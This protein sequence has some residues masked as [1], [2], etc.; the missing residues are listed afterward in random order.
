MI[1][2]VD[3]LASRANEKRSGAAGFG[4]RSKTKDLTYTP[5]NSNEMQSFMEFLESEE[6]EGLRATEIGFHPKSKLRGVF[7][8]ESFEEG[9]FV[10]AIPFVSTLLI[11]ES[12]AKD[13]SEIEK[14]YQFHIKHRRGVE[15]SKWKPYLDCLPTR[16]SHFSA[17]ADF[18]EDDAIEALQI[19][20][21]IQETLQRKRAIHGLTEHNPDITFNELQFTTWLVRSRAF[22][23]FKATTD[24]REQ[25]TLRSRS[26]FIP[27]IDFVNHSTKSN[28]EIQVIETASDD[29]SFFALAA[30]CRIAVGMEILLSYGTGREN[31]LDLFS[32]Y[33]F[34]TKNNPNDANLDFNSAVWTTTLKEDENSAKLASS[35]MN[36]ALT[37]RAHLKQIVVQ[38]SRVVE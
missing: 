37:L 30:T 13:S 16:E 26:V 31:T 33:G 7:A 3:G 1:E 17:T 32:K 29:E 14:A 6:C 21:L 5:D 11:D 38:N 12:F 2:L 15:S 36:D 10:V 4:V 9:E 23:T 22:S 34:Y 8:K 35:T 25:T 20:R 19:P 27:Y 28:V 24:G 18:W